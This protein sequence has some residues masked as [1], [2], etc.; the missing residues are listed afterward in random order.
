[1]YK[2]QS[3]LPQWRKA[4]NLTLKRNPF[5]RY[6][7]L[8]ILAICFLV[9]HRYLRAVV[10]VDES[11]VDERAAITY[12]EEKIPQRMEEPVTIPNVI[13]MSA[14][15]SSDQEDTIETTSGESGERYDVV[16]L[17]PNVASDAENAENRSPMDTPADN[18]ASNEN[19]DDEASSKQ[20][21]DEKTSDKPALKG[22]S[23]SH[24]P[25]LLVKE[26]SQ[27]LI[28]QHRS[29]AVK[30]DIDSDTSRSWSEDSG[31]QRRF[32][33]YF[34]YAA[35]SERAE[36]LPDIIHIPFEDAVADVKLSGWED[37]WFSEAQ[38]DIQ[39]YGLLNE[40]KIDFIYTCKTPF[41]DYPTLDFIQDGN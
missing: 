36:A 7:V 1:M 26:A 5:N 30:S 27:K 24:N 40:T 29:P 23:D 22:G 16:D 34:E 8:I 21:D 9:W 11:V 35:Q 32:P 15:P 4:S 38:L 31:A 14:S 37:L 39:K 18:G 33:A 41:Q 2:S 28:D 6:R 12:P 10:E 20:P 17:A 3:K 13:E 19:A 25:P